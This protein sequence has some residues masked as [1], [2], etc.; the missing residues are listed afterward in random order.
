MESTIY[1]LLLLLFISGGFG[2]VAIGL[3][4]PEPRE[5]RFLGK[6]IDLGFI[7]DFFIGGVTS[8]GIFFF[9]NSLLDYSG[10]NPE[11]FFEGFKSLK[12][13]S[14]GILS[15]VAG[16]NLL[17][18]ISNQLTNQ[19]TKQL[20]EL[21][22]GIRDAANQNILH[23]TATEGYRHLERDELPSAL[24][25]FDIVLKKDEYNEYALIG[26]AKVLRKMSE[27]HNNDKYLK[28]AIKLLEKLVKN[29]PSAMRAHYNLACYYNISKNHDMNAII[30][31]LSKAMEI[32]STYMQI[33]KNDP[34][35]ENIIHTDEFENMVKKYENKY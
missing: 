14:L 9:I 12:L 32:S 3:V 28:D 2:A 35:L 22:N 16:S 27:S 21:E 4:Y 5:I 26:K 18:K 34:D 19:L 8:I 31:S 30:E 33:A 6:N 1:Q 24:E 25:S 7:G 10:S 29:Q 23:D 15:G 13:I 20:T 17:R 11:K